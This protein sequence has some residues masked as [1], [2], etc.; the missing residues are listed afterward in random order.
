MLHQTHRL[1]P[2]PLVPRAHVLRCCSHSLTISVLIRASCIAV[3]CLWHFASESLIA[4]VIQD[5]RKIYNDTFGSNVHRV[6]GRKFN[7]ELPAEVVNTFFSPTIDKIADH[8]RRIRD[9]TELRGLHRVFLVGGF[10]RCVLLQRAARAVLHR[11]G[12]SVEIVHKPDIAIV[13]GAVLF[14]SKFSMFTTRKARLT[15]GVGCSQVYDNRDPEHR[16]LRD[17]GKTYTDDA[18]KTRVSKVFDAHVVIGQDIPSDGVLEMRRYDCSKVATTT[19]QFGICASTKKNP[20]FIDEEGCIEIG[21]A[22]VPADMT[23]P[24]KDRGCRIQFTYG[25]TELLVDILHKKDNRE[26]E[27]GLSLLSHTLR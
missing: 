27:G 2:S 17:A 14:H 25:G 5:R 26:I 9:S 15:Y 6:G 4:Y 21:E 8:L 10:S 1:M 24:L 19:F 20:R 3:C 13:K 12:C 18:G 16:R 22:A 23:V 7:V 11:D